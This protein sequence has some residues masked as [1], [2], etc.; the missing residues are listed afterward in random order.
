MLQSLGITALTGIIS[1]IFFIVLTW[2]VLQ[3][4]RI[5]QIFKKGKIME[6]RVLFMLI[7]I[8]IGSSVSRFFL[9]FLD[10]SQD[11]VYLF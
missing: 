6:A 4:V 9:E 5:E 10:W 3:S 1:H 7:T 8:M 11:L 2:K